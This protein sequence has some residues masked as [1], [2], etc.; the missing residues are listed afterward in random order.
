[1]LGADIPSPEHVEFNGL[2]VDMWPRISW[3]PLWALTFSQ[4]QVRWLKLWECDAYQ[5][6]RCTALPCFLKLIKPS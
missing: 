2:K 1:M 5:S 3:S 4:I 6:G